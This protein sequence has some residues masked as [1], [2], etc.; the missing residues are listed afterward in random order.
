MADLK[1][2]N[3]NVADRFYKGALLFQEIRN[4]LKDID[5]DKLLN[6]I[7]YHNIKVGCRSLKSFQCGGDL[8]GEAEG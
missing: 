4:S 3:R 8:V 6:R 1:R 5:K 7:R 2:G